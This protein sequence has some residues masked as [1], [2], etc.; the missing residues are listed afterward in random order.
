MFHIQ[1][2]CNR[3]RW[4][5][6]ALLIVHTSMQRYRACCA[7]YASARMRTSLPLQGGA[8]DCCLQSLFQ[9]LSRRWV[10]QFHEGFQLD[11]R[12]AV[13]ILNLQKHQVDLLLRGESSFDPPT[14]SVLSL[15]LVVPS[16]W[17]DANASRLASL[18]ASPSS[19]LLRSGRAYGPTWSF[20]VRR[21][22]CCRLSSHCRFR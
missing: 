2:S 9:P 4:V 13:S 10:A 1:R 5:H 3:Q 7:T 11:G 18:P 8:L 17:F 6:S 19:V 22:F 16:S 12:A 14:V 15:L 21:R 20:R